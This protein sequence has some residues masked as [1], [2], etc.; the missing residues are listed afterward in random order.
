[1]NRNTYQYIEII[2]TVTHSKKYRQLYM[3]SQNSLYQF[4]LQWFDTVG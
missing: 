1:M 4:C 3:H 2:Q